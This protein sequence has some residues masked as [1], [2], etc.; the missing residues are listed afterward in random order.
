MTV[1][2]TRR[3]SVPS[4][5][6][7]LVVLQLALSAL[8]A[9]NFAT[10]ARAQLDPYD[11]I[12][13]FGESEVG[14]P[15]DIAHFDPCAR[16]YRASG[17]GK[18]DFLG[19][20]SFAFV[21]DPGYAIH[22]YWTDP[23][24]PQL[25]ATYD[26]SS[27]PGFDDFVAGPYGVAVNDIPGHPNF[28]QV[29][30]C[31]QTATSQGIIRVYEI[32]SDVTTGST[33]QTLKFKN[34][35]YGPKEWDVLVFPR[36]LA[37]DSDGDVYVTAASLDTFQWEALKFRGGDVANK[38]N[39]EVQQA[40]GFTHSGQELLDVS[41]S[42]FDKIVSMVT[43]VHMDGNS[44]HRF[45]NDSGESFESEILG[46]GNCDPDL[47]GVC[48]RDPYGN[49]WDSI[50]DVSFNCANSSLVQRRN[51]DDLS[52]YFEAGIYPALLSPRGL[53]YRRAWYNFYPNPFDTG[54]SIQRCREMLYVCDK[55][56]VTILEDLP[57]KSSFPLPTNAVAWWSFDDDVWT[58]S[59]PAK[60]N[61]VY[62]RIDPTAHGK[63][64]G[65]LLGPPWTVE[66]V[67]RCA[68][69]STGNNQGVEIPDGPSVDF[70][71]GDLTIE[72]WI[73]ARR[74]PSFRVFVHKRDSTGDT[75]Y[76]VYLGG[77]GG[78]NL[79]F[80]T[81]VGG[82]IMNLEPSSGDTPLMIADE[83][84]HHFAVTFDQM[85][86]T[87]TLH[88]DGGVLAGGHTTVRTDPLTGNLDNDGN[89]YLLRHPPYEPR[90][91]NG[92]ID[93]LTFYKRALSD[94]E[95]RGI[96]EAGFAGKK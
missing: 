26:S 69:R 23:L 27:G 80:Q 73:R 16:V 9:L 50:V 93:E 46:P 38:R 33:Y 64:T 55:G 61:L 36:G 44:L 54:S 66:G 96:Y 31:A 11:G 10:L 29:Y 41:V 95:I 88:V 21:T 48:S 86:A 3:S 40:Y 20:R 67:V 78:G 82:T 71:D 68:I 57:P 81:I 35:F 56:N 89:L 45:R 63:K 25:F 74:Q 22:Q 76:S 77:P 39:G 15:Y 58:A 28:G 2:T 75:G 53:E 72:G 52:S 34:D 14:D 92:E 47:Q 7:K 85:L 87:V 19:G 32:E 43:T 6:L 8:C 79:S 30:V 4:A 5:P 49:V 42:P 37:V 84:W 62:N 65:P 17:P 94:I 12:T 90:G 83:K 13:T 24:T 70:G 91:L 59:N 18:L 60:H 1:T 51:H